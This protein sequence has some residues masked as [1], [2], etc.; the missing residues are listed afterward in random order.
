MKCFSLGD[1]EKTILKFWQVFDALNTSPEV[2]IYTLNGTEL[3][4]YR[5]ALEIKKEKN[6]NIYYSPTEAL[7]NIQTTTQIV[8]L[9]PRQNTNHKMLYRCCLKRKTMQQI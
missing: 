4:P 9:Q 7:L 3:K 1:K 5:S 2:T 8:V 6:K